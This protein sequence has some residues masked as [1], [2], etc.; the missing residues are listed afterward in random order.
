MDTPVV[1]CIRVTSEFPKRHELSLED[2]FFEANALC[3]HRPN[4]RTSDARIPRLPK[5]PSKS[6]HWAGA[7]RQILI[8]RAHNTGFAAGCSSVLPRQHVTEKC[9]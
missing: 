3:M 2:G 5:P 8:S 9:H 4:S 1:N 6:T 7:S